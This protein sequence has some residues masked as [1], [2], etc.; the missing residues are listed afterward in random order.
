MRS[1]DL[2]L[3]AC[4]REPIHVPSSIQPHGLLFVVDPATDRIVQ[5]AGDTAAVLGLAGSPLGRTVD[6]VLGHSLADLV[7]R[8]GV[9]LLGKPAYL[10]TLRPSG[11]AGALSVV[12]HG[13][14]AGAVVE[15]MPAGRTA[16]AAEALGSLRAATERIAEASDLGEACAVAAAE[17]RRV[18]GYDRVMIYRFFADGSG[19]VI[20]ES[21]A[22]RLA[23][24]LN[25][26]YPE[27][28]IP[29]QARELYR[30][31]AIRVIPDVSYT[32]AP[33]V[34]A[35]SPVTGEPLDMSHCALRRLDVGVAAGPGRAVG[36]H[37]LPQHNGQ[38]GGL[39]NPGNL[40]PRRPGAVPAHPGA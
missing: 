10:T 32:P 1:E 14:Q 36:T 24:F 17:M 16:S 2:D 12:A 6:D 28:D 40:P 30:R 21:K 29:R 37:R 11:A 25:H 26:R 27:S 19:A 9:G 4:A 8:S 13:A 35:I 15:V 22:A 20:A 7:Q 38:T 18:C 33:L 5:A 31:T 39:R 3:E 34:P 23:P